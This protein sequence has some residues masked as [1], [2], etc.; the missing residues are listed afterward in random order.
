MSLLLAQ[1]GADLGVRSNRGAPSQQLGA[2]HTAE[3]F[4]EEGWVPATLLVSREDLCSHVASLG[5]P[6]AESSLHPPC[7]SP[8]S[9]SPHTLDRAPLG[10]FSWVT[11]RLSQPLLPWR[12]PLYLSSGFS[13]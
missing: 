8:A 3:G 4:D 11:G 1:G 5:P 10:T 2:W 9:G 6:E 7:V 12:V 13:T